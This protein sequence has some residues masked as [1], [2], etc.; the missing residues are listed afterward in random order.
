MRETGNERF[1]LCKK[2]RIREERLNGRDGCACA[3]ECSSFISITLLTIKEFSFNDSSV[4]LL[5]ILLN[6]KS[7]INKSEIINVSILFILLIDD[8][9]VGLE[10]SLLV[11][12]CCESTESRGEKTTFFYIIYSRREYVWNGHEWNRE[13]R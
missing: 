13:K 10:A 7:N 11:D 1:L 8:R 2:K 5:S 12:L 6:R 9:Q 3:A 4:F